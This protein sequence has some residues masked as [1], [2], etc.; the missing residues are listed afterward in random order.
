[1]T[2]AEERYRAMRRIP[3]ALVELANTPG[4]IRKTAMRRLVSM[5]LRHYP[6]E[7]DFERMRR[8]C[9]EMLR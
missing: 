8:M 4:P 2:T 6:T 3:G 1:M 7:Y 5:L 9:K